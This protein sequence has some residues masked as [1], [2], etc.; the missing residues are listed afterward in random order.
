MLNENAQDR[1]GEKHSSVTVNR[2]FFPAFV[3]GGPRDGSVSPW[4]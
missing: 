4:V 1:K 3:L 2:T